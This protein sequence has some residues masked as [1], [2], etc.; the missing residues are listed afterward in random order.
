MVDK[1]AIAKVSVQFKPL[2]NFQREC[3]D[4][5]IRQVQRYPLASPT[6]R[7]PKEERVWLV[8]YFTQSISPSE[9]V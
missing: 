9:V 2:F 5:C 7:T 1:D 4:S 3:V 8:N 6:V